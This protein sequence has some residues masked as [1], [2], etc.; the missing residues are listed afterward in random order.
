LF[1]LETYFA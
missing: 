1:Q